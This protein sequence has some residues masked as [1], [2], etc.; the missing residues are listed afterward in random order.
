MNGPTLR[1]QLSSAHQ[2]SFRLDTLL[3]Q[4]ENRNEGQL[5]ARVVREQ[6]Y[7]VTV[8]APLAFPVNPIFLV[9][10]APQPDPRMQDRIEQK[11]RLGQA[12]PLIAPTQD[13][14]AAERTIVH[15]GTEQQFT[16]QI[17]F[18]ESQ[19]GLKIN[20]QNH[21]KDLFE[22]HLHVIASGVVQS[23]K[24]FVFVHNSEKAFENCFKS[25]QVVANEERSLN[26]VRYN[27]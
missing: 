1:V 18:P 25:L 22:V 14:Q 10:I 19:Y 21:R 8:T 17:R 27:F 2:S 7:T 4:M 13:S 15:G 9:A 24:G 12:G 3:G 6:V 20:V 16:F 11:Q 23:F 26:F 5:Y